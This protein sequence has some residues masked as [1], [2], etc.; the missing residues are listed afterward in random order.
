MVRMVYIYDKGESI[1]CVCKFMISR[2]TE[3]NKNEAGREA[4]RVEK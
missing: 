3:K 4:D 1:A 2:R